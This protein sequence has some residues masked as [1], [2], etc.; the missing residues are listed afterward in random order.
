MRSF[1]LLTL[2]ALSACGSAPPAQFSGPASTWRAAFRAPFPGSLDTHVHVAEANPHDDF[3]FTPRRA[4][5]ALSASGV[6]R[7]WI[8]AGAHQA[9]ATEELARERNAFVVAQREA[10]RNDPQANGRLVPFCA[11][12]IGPEW[13]VEVARAG[14]QNGCVGLKL[15]PQ[16]SGVDL[17]EEASANALH[18]LLRLAEEEHL[19][20]LIHSS[21]PREGEPTALLDVVRAHPRTRIVLAHSLGNDFRLLASA[22]AEHLYVET[23]AVVFWARTDDDRRELVEAWRAFGIDRVLFGSDWPVITPSE[24]L[25]RLSELP[26][27]DEELTAIVQTN[28]RAFDDLLRP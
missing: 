21:L 19:V 2:G 5:I 3:Q 11:V 23:S 16:A 25:H 18:A 27:T 20:V 15:H 7:A 9:S 8:L 26:L 10:A 12:P 14:A 13:S 17:R 28:A 24:T 1:I 6:E 4:L 22:R